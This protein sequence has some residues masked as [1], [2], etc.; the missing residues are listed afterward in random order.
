MW[1]TTGEQLAKNFAQ[2][3]PSD[4]EEKKRQALRDAQFAPKPE[5]TPKPPADASAAKARLAA[6]QKALQ[7]ELALY[8]A[9][10]SAKE[11][12]NQI[13][14]SEGL[15]SVGTY[16][17][18][19]RK[20]AK[21]E[22]DE[23]IAVLMAEK[24]AIEKNTPKATTNAEAIANRQKLADL[25][26][27][28]AIARVT[29]TKAQAELDE[30]EFQAVQA[31][32]KTVLGYQAQI[33]AAQGLTYQAAIAKIQSEEAEVKRAL[34]QA[35]LTPEAV[36]AMVAQIQQ[37][38]L[39][40]AAYDEDKKQG[41]DAF[42]SLGNAQN[43][44]NLQVTA[45]LETQYGAEKRIAQLELA[46]IPQLQAI[47]VA[48]RAAAVTPEQIQAAEDYAQKIKG[49]Q[50]AA[51][52][53]ASDMTKFGTEARTAIQGDLN[54]FLSTTIESANSVGDAFKK[55][56]TSVVESIQKIIT[57]LIVQIAMTRILKA[58]QGAGGGGTAGPGAGGGFS[59]MF[60]A[61]GYVSGRGSS[62][63]DSI[64]ARL[65]DGEFV[66][67]AAAV[68][69]IGVHTLAAINRGMSNPAISSTRSVPHFAEG[70]LVQTGIGSQGPMD[71][72][73]GISMDEGLTIKHL[74]SKKA[75]KV[76]LQ[77]LSNNPRAAN[78][79]IQRGR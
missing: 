57:Q 48:M 27:K 34:V 62:T 56:G 63:S 60:A 79:A 35:G 72:H 55:L 54:T 30:Q 74:S 50:V 40:T 44:I 17:A 29:G 66:V 4:D 33:L 65:S 37:L 51:T 59:E 67:R 70:G 23:E 26:N 15:E 16:F 8:K 53:A 73:L 11:Q 71:L 43:D 28:I 47:A 39:A 38:K 41:E 36:A 42:R 14:Y 58:M 2:I 6:L 22:S 49:I 13:S 32:Q 1:A 10:N 5:V 12:A 76:V 45:G 64:P 21:D 31:H 20:L 24:I 52:A 77:H 68:R 18:T 46:R 78:K 7:D 3:L 19:R 61:G 75:G 69:A 9:N 25:D